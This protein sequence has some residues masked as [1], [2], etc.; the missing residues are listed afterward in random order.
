MKW[1]DV[2]DRMPEFKS[3]YSRLK[4]TDTVLA[5]NNNSMYVGYF[6]KNI[7]LNIISFLGIDLDGCPCGDDIIECLHNITHWMPL[8]EPPKEENNET[9]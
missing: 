7:E 4:F 9:I 2:K 8:P 3:M 6:R 5:V 1:I